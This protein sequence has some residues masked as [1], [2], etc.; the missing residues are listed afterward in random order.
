M[1]NKETIGDRVRQLCKTLNL[2]QEQFGSKLGYWGTSNAASKGISKLVNGETP[3]LEVLSRIATV[4]GVSLDWLILG[5]GSMNI[6][7]EP[8]APDASQTSDELE[9]KEYFEKELATP[10]TMFLFF[11]DLVG[12]AD[13]LHSQ[14]FIYENER[15][16]ETNLITVPTIRDE[17]VAFVF[18]VKTS[19][20]NVNGREI[21]T[22]CSP[23]SKK[24]ADCAKDWQGI[25]HGE[26]AAPEYFRDGDRDVPISWG[27]TLQEAEA[28]WLKTYNHI[29]IPRRHFLEKVFGHNGVPQPNFATPHMQTMWEYQGDDFLDDASPPDPALPTKIKYI[30]APNDPML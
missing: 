28:E 30:K 13:R 26:K 1:D 15:P 3:N 20:I 8:P 19:Y 29:G 4:Y 14:C 25:Q 9:A 10:A 27:S 17:Y 7:N 16:R 12:L 6:S 24:F 5:R 22:A 18:P 2:T 23:M 11:R 21:A